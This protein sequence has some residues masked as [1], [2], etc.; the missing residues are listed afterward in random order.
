LI[1]KHGEKYLINK[2][3]VYNSKYEV[4]RLGVMPHE[5]YNS[6]N[7]NRS[8]N[9][10]S[11]SRLSKVKRV[12]L[13]IEALK[14]MNIN[15]NWTHIGDGDLKDKLLKKCEELPKNIKWNFVGN[16]SNEDVFEYYKCH[17][18]DLFINVSESEGIPV[19]IMEA[20]SFGIP[21]IATKVGGN[22]EIV[23]DKNGFLLDKHF[24]IE[25][26]QNVLLKYKSMDYKDIM[27][28]RKKA[29][30]EWDKKFNAITNFNEFYNS[31]YKLEVKNNE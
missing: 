7:K 9:I 25:E 19:S 17:P 4:S 5:E 31:L 8:L 15:V 12:G 30:I 13:I 18:I 23:N 6:F 21:V 10:L 2:F 28:K 1:S 27:I 16:I 24:N 14:N 22:I 3:P 11:C 26:L 20:M 29:Y